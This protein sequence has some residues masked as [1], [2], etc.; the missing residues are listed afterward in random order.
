MSEQLFVY[1]TLR[2][3]TQPPELVVPLR[4][5]YNRG[6]GTVRGCLYDAGSY[7]AAILDSTAAE[8][9][10]RGEI[11]ELPEDWDWAPCDRYEGYTP[12]SPEHSLFT[13]VRAAVRTQD[14]NEIPCWIYVYN[15]D[16]THLPLVQ[17]GIWL[18]KK[19]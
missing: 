6:T 18:P 16:T 8:T 1:G 2:R 10:I 13:R 15:R 11:L 12:K 4:R 9:W 7:P 3:G 14:G 17:G 19:R 5:C